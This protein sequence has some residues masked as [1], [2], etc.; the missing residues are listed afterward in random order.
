[1]ERV[2]IWTEGAQIDGVDR[3]VEVKKLGWIKG[4]LDGW[5]REVLG[6]DGMERT[7][8]GIRVDGWIGLLGWKDWWIR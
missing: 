7:G 1:M 8:R 6:I 5:T 3:W 2:L 4:K